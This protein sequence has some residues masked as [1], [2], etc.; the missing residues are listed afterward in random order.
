MMAFPATAALVLLALVSLAL[1]IRGGQC[2]VSWACMHVYDFVSLFMLGSAEGADAGSAEGAD[3]GPA[4]DTDGADADPTDEDEVPS[5]KD[6]RK[7]LKDVLGATLAAAR[8][9]VLRMRESDSEG[10]VTGAKDS[11]ASAENLNR[12]AASDEE[13]ATPIP[14]DPEIPQDKV[15]TSSPEEFG[16]PPVVPIFEVTA[17]AV[18]IS[19]FIFFRRR[20]RQHVQQL[21]LADVAHTVRRAMYP[22]FSPFFS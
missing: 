3:V 19:T 11:D 10:S 22:F 5:P 16:M 13:V 12:S 8:A 15:A 6:E 1:P 4:E 14:Q 2:T 20:R 17:I 18:V 7:P 21:P 9:W